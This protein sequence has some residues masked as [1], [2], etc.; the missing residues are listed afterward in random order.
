MFQKFGYSYYTSIDTEYIWYLFRLVHSYFCRHY[1]NKI[2]SYIETTF[3]FPE[4]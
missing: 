4:K 1:Q 2:F 3:F